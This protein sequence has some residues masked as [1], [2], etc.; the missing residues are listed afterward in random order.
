MVTI[1]NITPKNLNND[2]GSQVDY[3][4][5]FQGTNHNLTGSF[6]ATE[7][8]I[9]TAFKDVENGDMFA[10]VKK[11]VLSRLQTEAQNAL[12]LVNNK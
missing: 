12:N 11:L 5:N 6:V 8:E 2:S 10:G 9:A 1:N 3:S 4:V 7:D